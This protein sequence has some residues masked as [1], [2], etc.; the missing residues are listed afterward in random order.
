[1]FLRLFTTASPSQ[2]LTPVLRTPSP[3][4]GARSAVPSSSVGHKHAG[5]GISQASRG[6][7]EEEID[8]ASTCAGVGNDDR[9]IDGTADQRVRRHVVGQRGTLTLQPVAAPRQRILLC[10]VPACGSS[11]SRAMNAGRHRPCS[12]RRQRT[13]GGPLQCLPAG[14][15]LDRSP[16]VHVAP[17]HAHVRHLP[18]AGTRACKKVL[19]RLPR[20]HIHGCRCQSPPPSHCAACLASPSPHL[21]CN[22]DEE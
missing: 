12:W 6:V 1:M 8:G 7:R 9:C 19:S 16:V 13:A 15:F 18:P 21:A 22:L 2:A 3:L 4:P 11:R 20:C 5:V 10:P 14:A 17:A